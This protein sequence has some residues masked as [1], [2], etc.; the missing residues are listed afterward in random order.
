MAGLAGRVLRCQQV[1]VVIRCQGGRFTRNDVGALDGEVFRC[2]VSER[3]VCC[4]TCGN[5]GDVAS[6][7]CAGASGAVVL[8]LA[9]ALAFAGAQRDAEADAAQ[10]V[11]R[12]GIGDLLPSHA[13]AGRTNQSATQTL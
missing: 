6:S 7:L 9:G 5:D 1:D 2:V 11:G 4:C 3:S 10:F 13:A 8:D 12:V